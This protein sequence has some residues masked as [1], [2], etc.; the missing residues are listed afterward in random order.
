VARTFPLEKVILQAWDHAC[1]RPALFR[2]GRSDDVNRRLLRLIAIRTAILFLGLNLAQ[3]LGFLP[4]RIW[5]LP[6]LPL[7]NVFSVTLAFALLA[8]WWSGWKP[9]LQLR[10]QIAID[11]CIATVLVA[12]THGSE[13]PF[14]SFYLLIIIYC[15]LSLGRNGGVIG[16]ALSTILYAGIIALSHLGLVGTLV[17]PASRSTLAYRISLHALGFFSV[18]FLGADLSQR[19][20][21]V[22]EE[23]RLRIDSLERLQRLTEHIVSSIRSGLLTTDLDG[24]ITLFNASAEELMGTTRAEVINRSL[25]D[26]TDEG[27][28][29]AING[30]DL[31][32]DALPLRYEEWL[33]LPNGSRRFLGYSVSPL[34]DDDRKLIGY[35]VSFQNLTDIK[36][37]EEEIRAKERAAAIGRMAAGIAHEI[38][39]PLAAMRGSVEI[40]RSHLNPGVAHGRLLDILVRES[41]RLNK[42]VEDFLLFARPAQCLRK[43]LDLVP[44]LR[45][46]V[47]LLKNSPEVREKH[48]VDLRLAAERIPAVGDADKLRQVFWNLAQ[49]GLRA[50]PAGGTL[51]IAARETGDGGSEIDFEDAGTGMTEEEKSRL[52]QPFHS[53]FA[54]GAGLGLSIIRQ[55]MEDHRGSIRIDSEKGRG[56]KVTVHLAPAA[57]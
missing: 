38:R 30:A 26:V 14:V 7:F 56:T 23:L 37:L 40:L 1:A 17:E 11:L 19:L 43:P 44:L 52:F 21:T 34:L 42:F 22:Q 48:R 51:T 4:D 47:T 9:A 49:N 46:S 20:R 39:N 27:L 53:G 15:S 41:D 10:L 2:P 32:R 50:M 25:Q 24:R 57:E 55:I 13:S 28:W 35:I 18:A 36:R 54:G 45:D 31:F 29:G 12:H 3:P 6:F 33:R 8:I 16:A 5:T